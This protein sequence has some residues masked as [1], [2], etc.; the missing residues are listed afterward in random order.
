M[1]KL[2]LS[3]ENAAKSISNWKLQIRNHLQSLALPKK[4][5]GV[6]TIINQAPTN[7][8]NQAPT[9]QANQVTTQ[10]STQ[11]TIQASTASVQFHEVESLY[12]FVAKYIPVPQASAY[13]DP[14][15]YREDLQKHKQ[16]V[17]K[18]RVEMREF[19]Q[20]HSIRSFSLRKIVM[21]G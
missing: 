5:L 2:V 17:A 6:Y 7:Q 9:N 20:M 1:S 10:A 3:K 14:N 15:S 19:C 21:R 16:C 18:V 11:Q 4:F 13:A 12:D 8:T